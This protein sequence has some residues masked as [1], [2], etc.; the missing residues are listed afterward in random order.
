[1][2]QD[3]SSEDWQDIIQNNK[4]GIARSWLDNGM[5]ANEILAS[6]C[7]PLTAAIDHCKL[8]IVRLLITHKENHADTNLRD[9]YG[10]YP[11]HNAIRMNDTDLVQC[12][13]SEAEVPVDIN[14]SDK[15]RRAVAPLAYAV[16][17]NSICMVKILLEAGADVHGASLQ[18][19][20]LETALILAVKQQNYDICELLFN[21]N[22][23]VNVLYIYKVNYYSALG[24]AVKQSL[25]NMVIYLVEQRGADIFKNYGM[26]LIEAVRS[27]RRSC[28]KYFLNAG[29]ELHGDMIWWPRSLLYEAITSS[30]I[31]NEALSTTEPYT[32]IVCSDIT[33]SR[34]ILEEGIEYHADCVSELLL[35]GI[36]NIESSIS[37][38]DLPYWIPKTPRHSLFCHA[39]SKYCWKLMKLLAQLNPQ[40]LQEHWFVEH[41]WDPKEAPS[42]DLQ[43]HWSTGLFWSLYGN[44]KKELTQFIADLYKERKNP[45][46][47]VILCRTKI[48]KQLGLNPIPKVEKLPL[49]QTLKH[50]VQYKDIL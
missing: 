25:L 13:L 26:I 43:E 37:D 46:Q 38:D 41:P 28:L 14:M 30:D 45:P 12:L 50:F 23:N 4:V 35:W 49:P 27:N 42:E 9:G 47:L 22:C 31:W 3:Y 1:M 32:Y 11:I 19:N 8:D 16:K 15:K 7:T 17:L 21:Y 29:Y 2:F 10:N 5:D 40:Y 39:A 44:Q 33:G 18:I 36:N 6:W 48:F 20:K 34:A 24:E